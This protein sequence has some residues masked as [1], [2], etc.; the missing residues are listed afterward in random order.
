M[1]GWFNIYKSL[2]IIWH[3]SRSKDRNHWIISIDEEKALNKI[4]HDFMIKELQ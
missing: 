4:Q 2:N 1:Q 3:I